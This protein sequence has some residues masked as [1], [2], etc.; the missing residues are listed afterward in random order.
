MDMLDLA[1]MLC[2][3]KTTVRNLFY[4]LFLFYNADLSASF[5]EYFLY[6]VK[7]F[8]IYLQPKPFFYVFIT[9]ART[10]HIFP[11]ELPVGIKRRLFPLRPTADG[12]VVYTDA[13]Q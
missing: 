10:L 2:R 9:D 13:G 1:I 8:V 7:T 4:S 5:N 3:T 11:V 6:L 12:V